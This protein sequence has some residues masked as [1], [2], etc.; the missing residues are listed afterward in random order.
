[1]FKLASNRGFCFTL[2]PIV[3]SNH[4]VLARCLSWLRFNA[5]GFCV[6]VKYKFM[7]FRDCGL[8]LCACRSFLKFCQNMKL[9]PRNAHKFLSAKRMIQLAALLFEIHST[10]KPLFRVSPK[11]EIS[12]MNH[13]FRLWNVE[14][15][16]Y[17]KFTHAICGVKF[18][19]G[20]AALNFLGGKRID[21][22]CHIVM[23]AC[24]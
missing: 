12:L 3:Q 23:R 20:I 18:C 22:S 6:A 14:F 11:Y 4:R 7:S 8:I 16:H 24:V 13:E 9:Y 1:M 17:R 2:V 21:W 15:A 19:F 5:R 10:R